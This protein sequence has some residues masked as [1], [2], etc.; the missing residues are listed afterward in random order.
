MTT[1]EAIV[2]VLKDAGQPLAASEIAERVIAKVKLG[3]KTPK[4]T[5]AGIISSEHRKENGVIVKVDKG[6]YKIREDGDAP[7]ES[8]PKTAKP[9]VEKPKAKNAAK[10]Q[11][12]S[13]ATKTKGNGKPTTEPADVSH[14]RPSKETLAAVAKSTSEIQAK[15]AAKPDPK[16]SA[17]KR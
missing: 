14:M 11:A 8:V 7:G 12:K 9:K 17:R 16:P 5:V 4:A 13:R 10:S 6:T 15:R 1:K 3:G 2:S